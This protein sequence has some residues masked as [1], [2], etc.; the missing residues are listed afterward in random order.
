MANL[1]LLIKN[2]MKEQNIL[3]S[4]MLAVQSKSVKIFRNNVGVGWAGKSTHIKSKRTVTLFPGDV[5]IRNARPLRAGLTKGSSDLIGF[6][7]TIITAEMVG[8]KIG[9]F[10]ALE[11]KT[12]KGAIREEQLKF[13]EV[14]KSNGGIAGIVRSNEEALDLVGG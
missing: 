14:V 3:K 6:T 1:N 11:V 13:I 9:I 8:K 2:K 7:P 5:V 4:I 12:A 10:T